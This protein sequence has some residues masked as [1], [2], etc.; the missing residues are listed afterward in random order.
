MDQSMF[1]VNLRVHSSNDGSTRMIGDD[2][3]HWWE[4]E[5]EAS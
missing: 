2:G 3:N 5:G 1:E 4:S